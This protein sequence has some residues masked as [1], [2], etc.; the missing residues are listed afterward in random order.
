MDKLTEL[1][2]AAKALHE[3]AGDDAEKRAV[4]DAA[5]NRAAT[6]YAVVGAARAGMPSRGY[7][8]GVKALCP[9]EEWLRPFRRLICFQVSHDMSV[10]GERTA[11]KFVEHYSND[12]KWDEFGEFGL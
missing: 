3:A 2:D 12:P 1:F 9:D 4:A 10:R 8:A 7:V 5:A 11:R 6:A